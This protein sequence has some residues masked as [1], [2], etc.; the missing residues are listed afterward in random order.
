MTIDDHIEISM[1]HPIIYYD[2]QCL[3][4][5]GFIEALIKKDPKAIFKYCSLQDDKSQSVRHLHNM[6]DTINSVLL[7]DRGVWYDESDVSVRIA[8]H[9]DGPW[10]RASAMRYVPSSI[11][12]WIYRRIA[13][14]RYQ[15][16]GK[17]DQC[18]I[19]DESVMS[20][21]L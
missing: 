2:A 18:I 1:S 21:F 19:P 4:C 16:F 3:L 5:N 7:L 9:I 15:L 13:N 11:R 8:Q 6:T 20:R 14:N 10:H 12:N 17:S